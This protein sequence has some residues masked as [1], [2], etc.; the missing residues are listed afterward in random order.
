MITGSITAV[1]RWL[2]V[3]DEDETIKGDFESVCQGY[4][5]YLADEVHNTQ[6]LS[7]LQVAGQ[8]PQLQNF[9]NFEQLAK[10]LARAFNMEPDLV[11]KTDEQVQQEQQG[12]MQAQQQQL[13]QQAQTQLELE[14]GKAQIQAELEKYKKLLDEKQKVSDDQ[15]ESEMKERLE[16]I[17]QGNVLNPSQIGSMSILIGE[18]E[19]ER[20]QQMQ[21]QQAQQEQAMMQQ[22]MMQEQ[23]QVE[24]PS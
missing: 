21:M 14:Q 23:G 11:V 19:E 1:Y 18:E 13:Q 17:K 7:F 24:V 4:E 15:R 22:Q 9:F 20:M 3:D 12:A 5:R 16:L 2:M 6:L 10:P 8:S